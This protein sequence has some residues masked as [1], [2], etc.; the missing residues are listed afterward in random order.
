MQDRSVFDAYLRRL[1]LDREPPSVDAL[2]RLHRAHIER[3][4]YET[5][6]IAMGERWTID[7]QASIER[8]ALHGRGGYCLHLNGAFAALLTELG[9]RVELHVG[10]VYRDVPTADAM[11]NHLVLT[12]HDLPTVSNP[13]GVWYVDVGLGDA[14]HEPLP[15]MAGTYRQGVMQFELAATPGDIGDWRFL[16]DAKGSFIGMN[17]LDN[18]A[19]FAGFE[20]RHTFLS[21][22]PE[23]GFVR[24]LS[25][26]RRDHDRITILRALTLTTINATSTSSTVIDDR[27]QWLAMLT[28]TFALDLRTSSADGRHQLW[29]RAVAAHMEHEQSKTTGY[30]T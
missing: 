4:P 27:T 15:L 7:Q 6:W 20:D 30:Q 1:G 5:T 10:G 16:H 2:F 13:A 3:V 14:L 18:P 25:L 17:F 8:I 11:T 23:S 24:T 22:S 9:Y 21:T 28:D 29:Q 26:Q 19:T 12:V